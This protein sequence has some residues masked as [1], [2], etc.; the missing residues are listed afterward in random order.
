MGNKKVYVT[1][2][3]SSGALILLSQYFDVEVNQEDRVLNKKELLKMVENVDALLCLINDTVDKEVIDRAKKV[4]IIAN[5]GVGYNNIDVE[6]ATSRGIIV[7]NTPGVLT[8]AT[9]DLAWGLLF[10]VARRIAESDRFARAGEYKGW[11]PSLLLGMDI[12][13]KTLGVIGTGRIGKAFAKKSAGFD[14]KILYHNRRRNKQFERELNAEWVDKDTLLKE[15]D[16]VS[17][18]VPLTQET[19]HLIGKKELEIMKKT[20]IL[21]NT[22]RGPVVDENALVK[23]LKEKQIWGAGLD[24]YENEPDIEEELISLDN[25]VLLPHLGS[26]TNETRNKMAMMAAENVVAVLNGQKPVNP[27]N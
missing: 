8:D 27:V 7:T 24:V 15:S 11:S 21:I 13:G 6:A 26:A 5:Y 10:A 9:A 1:R 17:L 16:F 19:Y 18:H 3:I 20:A 4:K 25:V 12:T 14:M 22:S 23:A 2:E